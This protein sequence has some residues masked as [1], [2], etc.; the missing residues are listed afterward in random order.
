MIQVHGQGKIRRVAPG[1]AW[2]GDASLSELLSSLPKLS[3]AQLCDSDMEV[4]S[5]V[6]SPSTA[7]YLSKNFMLLYPLVKDKHALLNNMFL[8]SKYVQIQ[9]LNEPER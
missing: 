5:L 4:T 1:I 2:L 9:K 8:A 6:K 3:S 7:L